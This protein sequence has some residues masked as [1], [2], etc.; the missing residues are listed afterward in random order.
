MH[1]VRVELQDQGAEDGGVARLV[2]LVAQRAERLIDP[3]LGLPV[4]V[5]VGLGSDAAEDEGAAE[6]LA[7]EEGIEAREVR[8][9]RRQQARVTQPSLGARSNPI[10]LPRA[11]SSSR[12]GSL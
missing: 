12:E 7:G 9:A 11:R 2:G 1:A 5:G 4:G 8:F 10:T 3:S 6:R